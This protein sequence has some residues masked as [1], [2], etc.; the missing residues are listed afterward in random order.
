[1]VGRNTGVYDRPGSAERHAGCR[2]AF[3]DTD[4]PLR[5]G[6]AAVDREVGAG[7]LGGIVAAEKQ[8]QGGDLL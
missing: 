3:R 1:M 4:A 7:D 6:P 2:T 8:R 5:R